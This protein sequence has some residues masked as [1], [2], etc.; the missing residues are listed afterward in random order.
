M[1]Q[2]NHD[3][4]RQVNCLCFLFHST[5]SLLFVKKRGSSRYFYDTF[6]YGTY[7][8]LKYF[9]ALLIYEIYIY[10]LNFYKTLLKY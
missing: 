6:A 9:N 3:F 1:L 4:I 5:D 10:A 2:K 8:Y 7:V